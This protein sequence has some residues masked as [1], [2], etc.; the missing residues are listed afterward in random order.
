MFCQFYAA[1]GGQAALIVMLSAGPDRSPSATATAGS[2]SLAVAVATASIDPV[3]PDPVSTDPASLCA[4][5]VEVSSF[6]FSPMFS[7]SVRGV[8]G[9]G[10]ERLGMPNA[11]DKVSNS[12][13][14]AFILALRS[15][16]VVVSAVRLASSCSV[17]T[18]THR[19]VHP[20]DRAFTEEV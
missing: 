2:A 4:P 7:C 14:I 1:A 8:R 15:S 9:G 10:L 5:A 16:S 17:G 13:C 11:A 20:T 19:H 6:M 12:F 3:S 18:F